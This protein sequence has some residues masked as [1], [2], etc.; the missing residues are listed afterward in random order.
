MNDSVCNGGDGDGELL[1]NLQL[2]F[3]I[4]LGLNLA[5]KFNRN[6]PKKKT[7]AKKKHNLIF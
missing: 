1:H 6:K 3:P 5:G 7:E 4:T 2:N